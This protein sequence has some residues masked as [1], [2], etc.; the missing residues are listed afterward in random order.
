MG[1]YDLNKK[2]KIA[3]RNDF[4]L[5]QINKLTIKFGSNLSSINFYYCLKFHIPMCQRQFF[6]RI[7]QN[8]E[9]VETH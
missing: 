1:L 9:Y 6:R 5:N 8:K 2:L 4:I 3:R 7:S